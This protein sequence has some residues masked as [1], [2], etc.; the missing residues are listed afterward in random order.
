MYINKWRPNWDYIKKK[1]FLYNKPKY[2]DRV[3][4]EVRNITI[5]GYVVRLK[6]NNN[7]TNKSLKGIEFSFYAKWQITKV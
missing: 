2:R 4:I 1:N 5:A 6:K 7:N 3:S